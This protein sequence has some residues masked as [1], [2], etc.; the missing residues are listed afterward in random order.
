MEGFEG[1]ATP[2]PP[3]LRAEMRGRS[4]K[5]DPR[6][7]AFEELA[8]L[9]M[10]HWGF[11]GEVHRG[12]MIV[13]ADVADD[14]LAVFAAIFAARFPIER[15][16]RIDAFD[17]DDEASMAANNASAFCFRESLAGHLSEHAL[18]RAIDINPVQNPM[19][20]RGVVYPPAGREYLDR[21]R[22]R[23]GMIVRPGPVVAAFDAIGWDWGGDWTSYPDYH[24]F[25]RERYAL[26]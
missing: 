6:C 2:V 10:N 1:V 7:P 14:A 19:V 4:W 9:R 12:E 18:G 3:G 25:Q 8:L 20:L 21:Q 26:R 17:A 16:A 23:P 22:V 24:H 15:M 5:D 11:D 13:A